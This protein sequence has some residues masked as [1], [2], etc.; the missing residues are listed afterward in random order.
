MSSHQ[1]LLKRQFLYHGHTFAD[2]LILATSLGD[3]N[4]LNAYFWVHK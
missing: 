3:V 1:T 2:D 4:Y